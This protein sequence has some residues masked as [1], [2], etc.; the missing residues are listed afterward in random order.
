VRIATSGSGAIF[1]YLLADDSKGH[2]T[3]LPIYESTAA[4]CCIAAAFCLDDALDVREDRLSRGAKSDTSTRSTGLSRT[5]GRAK[6][7]RKSLT[8][9]TVGD[10]LLRSPLLQP[11]RSFV[12][13]CDPGFVFE[14][15]I[16]N[17]GPD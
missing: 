14:F 6:G 11:G 15:Q 10:A 7:H 13:H 4:F 3:R 2:S 12:E 5:E 9:F 16:F 17:N 1:V 8:G